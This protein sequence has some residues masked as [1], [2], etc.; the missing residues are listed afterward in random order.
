MP[1]EG[2]E[3]V[4]ADRAAC[5][6]QWASSLLVEEATL[7]FGVA[8]AAR[9]AAGKAVSVLFSSAN[10]RYRDIVSAKNMALPG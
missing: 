6:T 4:S 10:L 5:L 9:L 1:V 2:A 8:L 7:S 3:A